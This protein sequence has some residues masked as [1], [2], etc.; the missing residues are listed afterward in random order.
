MSKAPEFQKE[1]LEE[2]IKFLVIVATERIKSG[3]SDEAL[4]RYIYLPC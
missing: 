1:I 3:S 2:F 4:V